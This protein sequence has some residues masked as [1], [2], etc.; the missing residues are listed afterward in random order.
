M[1]ILSDEPSNLTPGMRVRLVQPDATPHP[2]LITVNAPLMDPPAEG[3]NGAISTDGNTTSGTVNQAF[4]YP[5]MNMEL[6]PTVT[7]SIGYPLDADPPYILARNIDLTPT[8]WPEWDTRYAWLAGG[9]RHAPPSGQ[10][11]AFMQFICDE[12][13]PSLETEFSI[14][15]GQWSLL[16]HSLGGLFSTHVALSR[17]TEFRRYF[18]VGASYWWKHREIFDR[19]ES[20]I[21]TPEDPRAIY[22]AAGTK[23]SAA[24]LEA[25]WEAFMT[26]PD[27][28]EYIDLMGGYPDIWGDSQ[29]MAWL[30]SKA[31]GFESE[32]GSMTDETHGSAVLEALTRG[33]RWLHQAT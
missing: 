28:P 7:V 16:G 3:F 19:I 20:F 25:G 32:F 6:P 5:A 29:R 17:P 31:P 14:N 2:F 4:L 22:I 21:G 27:W 23:E 12:L 30:L 15:A 24:G 9:S 18:A 26:Q 1:K 13:K 8:P 11:D 33:V 10:A